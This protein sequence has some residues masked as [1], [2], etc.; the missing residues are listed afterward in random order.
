MRGNE[1]SIG[2]NSSESSILLGN[3]T[4]SKPATEN[5]YCKGDS[6]PKDW[7]AVQNPT[8]V[9]KLFCGRR[10]YLALAGDSNGNLR[11]TDRGTAENMRSHWP[12]HNR[13]KWYTSWP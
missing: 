2:L 13:V 8:K 6:L 11:P 1:S 7:T 12:G 4:V 5:S 3:L 9:Y 10:G